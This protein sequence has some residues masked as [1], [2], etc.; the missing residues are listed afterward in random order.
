MQTAGRLH[1]LDNVQTM[2]GGSVYD[3]T[4][5]LTPEMV[6]GKLLLL[7]P[8]TFQPTLAFLQSAGYRRW[9]GMAGAA[10]ATAN[11]GPAAIPAN[12]LA[13]ALRPTA[14]M[15]PPTADR[16][17]ALLITSALAEAILGAAA[18]NL[19]VGA[20]G[21][22]VSSDFRLVDSPA[23]AYNV[24]AMIP[25]TDPLLR[26]EFVII[27]AHS[28]HLSPFDHREHDSVRVFNQYLRPQGAKSPVAIP[29]EANVAKIRPALDS[30][31]KLR[32]GRVDSIYNGADDSGTGSVSALEIAEAFAGAAAKPKRSILF[33]WH[34]GQEPG[35]WGST[36][37][38]AHPTIPLES[39]VAYLNL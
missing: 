38:V 4:T 21:Q 29:N 20:A 23:P 7:K 12:A 19:T 32:P 33:V 27:G 9:V 8:A 39:A 18:S 36:W 24:I 6:R 26:N 30:I 15:R 16:Q 17:L 3:T 1:Q 37:F 11:F 5:T 13:T 28:D 2:Y 22:N 35:E 25:G 34:T 31:R 10:V 14:P